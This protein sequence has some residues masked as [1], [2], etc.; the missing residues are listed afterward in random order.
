MNPTGPD[1]A[2]TVHRRSIRCPDPDDCHPRQRRARRTPWLAAGACPGR[3]RPDRSDR[4][5][6]CLWRLHDRR[7]APRRLCRSARHGDMTDH[8]I[9]SAAAHRAC[10][11]RQPHPCR[12]RRA[13]PARAWS[14]HRRG[15]QPGTEHRGPVAAAAAGGHAGSGMPRADRHPCCRNPGARHRCTREGRGRSR[16]CRCVGAISGRG[17]DGAAQPRRANH[18]AGQ[19]QHRPVPGPVSPAHEGGRRSALIFLVQIN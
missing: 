6:P 17:L 8:N 12:G 16:P 18:P 1:P 13:E 11:I 19:G 5:V 10:L 7:A 4:R 3:A 15:R 2:R 14:W 9:L